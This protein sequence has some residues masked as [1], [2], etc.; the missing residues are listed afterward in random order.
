MRTILKCVK[1]T[2]KVTKNNAWK[3][4]KERMNR[5]KEDILKDIQLSISSFGT[6]ATTFA[7]T[8]A[9]SATIFAI[10]RSSD[11]YTYG[12]STVAVLAMGACISLAY[13]KKT[14]QFAN[15]EPI[16]QWSKACRI[17]RGKKQCVKLEKIYEKQRVNIGEII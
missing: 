3:R 17:Q 12:V 2:H 14:S 9:F 13:N 5:L 11:T 6:S 16:K 15:I 10:T 4:L 7:T 8:S 1:L